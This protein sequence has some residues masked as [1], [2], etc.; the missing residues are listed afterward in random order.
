MTAR[1]ETLL[2]L[3]QRA[4]AAVLALAVLIHL[5]T[6]IYAVRGGLTAAEIIERLQG[7]VA[8][9]LFYVIFIFAAAVHAPLGLRTILAE[10]TP[11][12]GPL[13]GL[14]VA[15]FGVI[16]AV[17]GWRAALALFAYGGA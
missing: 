10:M 15:A 6:V 17:M 7:N 1:I 2:W 4:S 8:W 12:R 13:L 3:A 16:V 14:P 5:G 9:L 11:L